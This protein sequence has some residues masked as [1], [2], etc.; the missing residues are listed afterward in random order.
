MDCI[1]EGL[2]QAYIDG[3]VSQE[4]KKL[5]E[6]HAS[7]CKNCQQKIDEQQKVSSRIVN[8]VNLLANYPINVEYKIPSKVNRFPLKKLVYIA[9]AACIL[10]FAIV[11]FKNGDKATAAHPEIYYEIDCSVDANLPITDQELMIHIYDV[12]DN[13]T[14]YSIQ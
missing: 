9:T 2:I 6:A 14:D 8:A 4:E 5:I 13:Q 3:E 10:F 7:V 12:D 1:S 11:F